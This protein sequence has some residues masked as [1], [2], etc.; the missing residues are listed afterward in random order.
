MSH[1]FDDNG[2]KYG[3]EGDLEDWWSKDT[4]DKFKH[5]TECL[6]EQYDNLTLAGHHVHGRY[7]R[8]CC[9]YVGIKRRI[10]IIFSETLLVKT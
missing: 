3:G 2:R 10:L 5:H 9:Y 6:V 8:I 4:A 7:G 1:A